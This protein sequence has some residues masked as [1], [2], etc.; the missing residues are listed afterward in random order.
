[1][2]TMCNGTLNEAWAK[3]SITVENWLQAERE[4]EDCAEAKRKSMM[5]AETRVE[6]EGEDWA[7]A[8]DLAL[9]LAA[10]ERETKAVAENWAKATTL[11]IAEAESATQIWSKACAATWV[12]TETEALIISI[13][14]SQGIGRAIHWGLASMLEETSQAQTRLMCKALAASAAW[15]KAKK[16]CETTSSAAK[17]ARAVAKAKAISTGYP[18]PLHRKNAHKE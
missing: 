18:L 5:L 1:M 6:A 13:R 17:V 15:T 3:A 14:Q 7:I 9:G 10:D 16:I 12:Q 4:A 8:L 2:M 11:A